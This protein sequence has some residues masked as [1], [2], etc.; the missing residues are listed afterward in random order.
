MKP[1]LS[2]SVLSGLLLSALL[3][4]GTPALA[5]DAGVQP[6][7]GPTALDIAADVVVLR[8]LGVA[9]T[10]LGTGLFI[11]ALPFSLPSD[12]VDEVADKLVADPAEFTFNRPLGK[13]PKKPSFR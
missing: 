9:A 4:A 5:Q 7:S 8:P 1:R 11:L 2:I 6:S 12:S 13:L 10:A 3:L